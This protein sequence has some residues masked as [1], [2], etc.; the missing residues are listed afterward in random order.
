[1]NKGN[2]IFKI[3]KENS[4]KWIEWML[5]NWG[6][7]GFEEDVLAYRQ[8]LTFSNA[9]NKEYCRRMW[10]NVEGPLFENYMISKVKELEDKRKNGSYESIRIQ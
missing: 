8:L 2:I 10:L 6:D 7:D 5:E 9:A 1:M 4:D 3:R